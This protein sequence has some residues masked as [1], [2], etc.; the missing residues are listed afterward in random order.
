MWKR[1]THSVWWQD[2]SE[3]LFTWWNMKSCQAIARAHL[4]PLPC[5]VSRPALGLKM[6]P[7]RTGPSRHV[8][9]RALT[10]KTRGARVLCGP[11]HSELELRASWQIFSQLRS[12]RRA[13]ESWYQ[14]DV[15]RVIRSHMSTQSKPQPSPQTIALYNLFGEK[16]KLHKTLLFDQWAC[17]F[18]QFRHLFVKINGY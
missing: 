13:E 4:P 14:G 1:L 7:R 12:D 15:S 6:R 9:C 2:I 3:C 8:T 16:A 5:A 18:S 11:G 10:R 17:F